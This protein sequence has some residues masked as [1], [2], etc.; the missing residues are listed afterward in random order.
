MLKKS[1]RGLFQRRLAWGGPAVKDLP[2]LL[3]LEV[4]EGDVVLPCDATSGGPATPQEAA[5]R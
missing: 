3:V 1:I 5:L 2:A 4:G